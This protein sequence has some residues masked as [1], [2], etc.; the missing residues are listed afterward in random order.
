MKL[1]QTEHSH[2]PQELESCQHHA[3]ALRCGA[4]TLL[5]AVP[6]PEPLPAAEG[7][8]RLPQLYDARALQLWLL[9]CCQTV[10]CVGWAG[11]TACLTL[12][13]CTWCQASMTDASH[14]MPYTAGSEAQACIRTMCQLRRVPTPN[15]PNRLCA[16]PLAQ[17]PRGGLRDKPG[18]SADYYH[19]C[20]CLR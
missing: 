9:K 8:E 18:K 6:P 4:A 1:K 17:P 12:T 20:Y 3:D 13:D 10:C 14:C 19:T 5:A 16:L 7:Q 2:A 11:W 15:Q